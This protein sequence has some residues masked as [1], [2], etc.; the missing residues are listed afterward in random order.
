MSTFDSRCR[1]PSKLQNHAL[2][3]PCS[4]SRHDDGP[5]S[6]QDSVPRPA[7]LRPDTP[8]QIVRVSSAPVL[9]PQPHRAFER[10]PI[11]EA[12][13]SA[14]LQSATK[15]ET[16]IQA[17]QDDAGTGQHCG[18]MK[19]VCGLM[20]DTFEGADDTGSSRSETLDT[21]LRKAEDEMWKRFVFNDDE[22]MSQITQ[23]TKREALQ[24]TTRQ[25]MAELN[26]Q[27]QSR[28]EHSAHSSTEQHQQRKRPRVSEQKEPGQ[29]QQGVKRRCSNR[30]D[31]ARPDIRTI[32]DHDDD[33]IE[34]S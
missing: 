13:P 22:D 30:R 28:V 4:I 29:R 5:E 23:R 12:C 33:P 32:P 25:L 26:T 2:D 31:K 17:K 1:E 3:Q 34:S 10:H 19:D 7:S 8:Q 15:A 9:H 14:S 21:V 6:Y 24:Q 18:K 11:L 20:S 27:V 16:M